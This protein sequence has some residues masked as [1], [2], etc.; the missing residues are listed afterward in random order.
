MKILMLHISDTHIKAGRLSR[1]K[2]D[3]MS[4]SLNAI[5]EFDECIAIFSGDVAYSGN[6]NE[7]KTASFFLGQLLSSIKNKTGSFVRLI[8]APGNHD[9]D[10][11]KLS[12]E[13]KDIQEQYDSGAIEDLLPCE[14]T[15]L[16]SYFEF[17]Q[18]YNKYCQRNLF[19]DRRFLSYQD[20]KMQINLLNTAFFST[21]KP[22]DKELHYF[23]TDRLFLLRKAGTD[24]DVVITV[25]HHST[26]W[27]HWKSKNQLESSIYESSSLLFLGHDH[28]PQTKS[29]EVDAHGGLIISAGG[30]ID[31]TDIQHSDEYK[32]FVLDTSTNTLDSYSFSWNSK[33]SIYAHKIIF[34]D[35]KMNDSSELS[36][37]EDFLQSIKDDPERS[38]SSDF[39][40]YFVFPQ[41]SGKAGEEYTE[42]I[43]IQSLPEFLIELHKRKFLFI[44]SKGK[45]GKTTLLRY[46]YLSTLKQGLIPLYYNVEEQSQGV[47]TDKLIKRLFEEQY[48]DDVTYFERY[49]QLDSAKKIVFVDNFDSI[50]SARTRSHLLQH[51]KKSIGYVIIAT[52]QSSSYDLKKEV[53]DAIVNHDEFQFLRINPFYQTQRQMLIRSICEASTTLN[54]DEIEKVVQ[55]INTLVRSP[56]N[57]FERTPDF[58][59]QYTQFFVQNLN[60]DTQKGEVIFSK[61]FAT[62]IYNAIIKYSQDD[63]E[64]IITALEELAY[65]MH[66]GKMLSVSHEMLSS[67]IARYNADYMVNVSA[68]ELLDVATKAKILVMVNGTFDIKFGNV[69]QMAFFVAN[70]LIRRFQSNGDFSGIEHVLK[71]ICFGINDNIVLFISYLTSNTKIIMS[72]LDEANKILSEWEELSFDKS[73]IKLLTKPITNEK[74]LAPNGDEKMR[75]EEAQNRAEE[76]MRPE[77]DDYE[78]TNVYDYDELDIEKFFFKMDRAVKYTEMIAKALPGFHNTLL[79]TQKLELLSGIYEFPNRILYAF[80]HPIDE[81]YE[82][83]VSELL[84]FATEADAKDGNGEPYTT[85]S[86]QQMMA[87]SAIVM[88]L[89]FYNEITY[90]ATDKKSL[91]LINSYDCVS[92]NHQIFHLM[93]LQHH[94]DTDAFYKAAD[95][96]Y[97][98]NAGKANILYMIQQ[99]VRH[100]LIWASN[101]DFRQRTRLT[102]RFFAQS[103]MINKQLLLGRS[104]EKDT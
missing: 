2:I 60:Q 35:K 23:P 76:Q 102:Q 54:A 88:S 104:K 78:L 31:L 42:D 25:M 67:I 75:A 44:G 52:S 15:A 50:K 53:K 57:L 33:S 85:D 32:A 58:I 6:A 13:G 49:L 36:P 47:K 38:I 99:I 93:A 40:Q 65:H 28:Y 16:D 91:P 100:H 59:I 14:I 10:F 72:I 68:A 27:F 66:F 9:L 20:F 24:I 5:G 11:S 73:N 17:A 97:S 82:Y 51:L 41:L 34:R 3:K 48:G 46:L 94:G 30:V 98:D 69:N 7:Y 103:G 89:N 71:N 79:A 84:S 43:K 64:G 77:E 18:K 21:R 96:L 1:E 80:L 26:D 61:V 62:N 74:D 29:L 92:A 86:I 70:A 87:E 63:S 95:K 8:M 55:T 22:D 81:E 56:S 101:I 90:L 19:I 39:T 83:V 12:R 45:L 37:L 4:Q